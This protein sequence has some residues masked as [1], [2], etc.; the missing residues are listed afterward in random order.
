MDEELKKLVEEVKR[1]FEAFKAANDERLKKIEETG[2][3]DPLLEEATTKAGEAITALEAKIEEHKAKA[4]QDAKRLDDLERSY[5]DGTVLDA[6]DEERAKE[7]RT[8]M[9]N[10]NIVH[11][12]TGR[13]DYQCSDLSVEDY[14]RYESAFYAGLRQNPTQWSSERRAELQVGVDPDGGYWVP[15]VL[16]E[17]I[18]RLILE[19][20]PIRMYISMRTLGPDNAGDAI[21]GV[22]QL[23]GAESGWVGEHSER[24]DTDD[25]PLAEWRIALGEL[26]AMPR[27]TQRALEFSSFDIESWLMEEVAMQFAR[28]ENDAFLNGPDGINKPQGLLSYP[29]GTPTEANWNQVRQINTGANG[30]FPAAGGFDKLIDATAALK[31]AYRMNS[32]WAMSRTTKAAIRKIKDAD[33]QYMLQPNLQ[34]GTANTLLEFPIVEME[35]IP[36]PSNGSLSIIFG[37]LRQAYQGVQRPGIRMIRDNVTEKGIVKFYSYTY[38]GGAVKN[39]EAYLVMK[40]SA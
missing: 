25:P 29:A 5:A 31:V 4:E 24:P 28:Q 34:T 21:M 1:E 23:G 2:T 14:G 22:Y 16:E 15:T 6:V 36:D 12:S 38:V 13:A 40:F 7:V 18:T 37:D 30:G 35:D 17:G 39:Y 11:N 19:T 33:G 27:S 20:S 26:Y 32:I 3:S 10:R 9:K 8:F